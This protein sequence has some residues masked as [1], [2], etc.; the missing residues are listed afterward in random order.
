[1]K[2]IIPFLFILFSLSVAAQSMDNDKNKTA[3][4]SLAEFVETVKAKNE[5]IKNVKNINVM[6]NDLLIEDLNGF[7]IDPKNVSKLEVLVLEPNGT[8]Q[9]ERKPSIIITTKIK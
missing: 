3:T 7:M 8:K 9:E 6:V 4:I 5:S 1:M 2:K